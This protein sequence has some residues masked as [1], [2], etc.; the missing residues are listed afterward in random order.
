MESQPQGKHI[1]VAAVWFGL[2]MGFMEGFAKICLRHFHLVNPTR[3]GSTV[4]QFLWISAV[5]GILVLLISAGVLL[6]MQWLLPGEWWIRVSVVWFAFL[7]FFDWIALSGWLKETSAMLLAMGLAFAFTRW[8][9]NRQTEVLGFWRHSLGWVV[10]LLVL[11]FVAV[12]ATAWVSERVAIAGLPVASPHGPKNV[13]V[14]VVDT[15][16]SDHLSAY[17]YSRPTSPNID[18]I[19]REGTLFENAFAP[20]S[21]TFPSHAS[22]LTGRYPHEHG[23]ETGLRALDARFPTIGEVFEA[24]GRRTGGFSANRAFFTRRLGLARGFVHFEDIFNSVIDA[25]TRTFYGRFFVQHG[26]RRMGYED[27]PGRKR[28]SDVTE[29]T[30]KWIDSDRDKPFFAF[31]NFFDTHDPYL[32]P[33]PF[34]SRFSKPG[35]RG[36]VINEFVGRS[37]PRLS[38]EQLQGEI[39]AYDGAITYVDDS[40]GKLL[41]A[42]KAQDLLKDTLVVVTSDHGESFGEHGLFLHRNALYRPT[43]QV[44]LIFWW[45]GHIPAGVRVSQPVSNIA[46]AATLADLMGEGEKYSFVGP[47]LRILW[48][49]GTP[50]P[51]PLPQA[52]LAQLPFEFPSSPCRYGRMESLLDSHWHYIV[53]EKYGAELYE[54]NTDPRENS[55][56]AN[57]PAGVELVSR[58][59]NRLQQRLAK[60]TWAGADKGPF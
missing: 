24:H 34:R 53:H 29:A 42:L 56:F 22:L 19:A 6:S 39:D 48:E 57:T 33:E 44:P 47:S 58:F 41:A 25:G 60:S 18:Q 51:W 49:N 17:G 45:P 59:A 21:W 38:A 28:A 10:G 36:G 31:L 20:S 3:D 35:Y 16:R 4:P 7:T 11:V 9:R 37:S 52:E 50:V 8:F 55:N 5:A 32:P 13:L 54:W 15:L 46:L 1:L 2:V 26:L 30:L 43:L 14:I 12:Q 40:I 27:D 23:A